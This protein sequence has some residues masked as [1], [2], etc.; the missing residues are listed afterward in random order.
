MASPRFLSEIAPSAEAASKLEMLGADSAE[1]LAALIDASRDAFDSYVGAGD[2]QWIRRK[3][4]AVLRDHGGG[5][6]NSGGVIPGGLGVPLGAAPEGPRVPGFDVVK[7]D[8][9]FDRI[10]ALRRAGA[11]RDD[12]RRLEVELDTML[13]GDDARALTRG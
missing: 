8:K 3:L 7:R 5:R 12:I 9:M 10:Q 1:A 11:P 6:G 2:A 13:R 4:R